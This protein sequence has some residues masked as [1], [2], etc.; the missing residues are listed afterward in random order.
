[1]IFF[2]GLIYYKYDV[3]IFHAYSSEKE[4]EMDKDRQIVHP[5]IENKNDDDFFADDASRVW[6]K[7]A[8]EEALEV[9]VFD[10]E[11]KNEMMPFSRRHK[12]RMNRFF[13]ERVGTSSLP[14]PEA[15]NLFER[16]RSRIVIK[17]NR[18]SEK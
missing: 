2:A 3:L 7:R 8:L 5:N 1:L 6:F 9:D 11:E 14:Y 4:E 17:L 15:D 10:F 16:I 18:M 13:R 12:I